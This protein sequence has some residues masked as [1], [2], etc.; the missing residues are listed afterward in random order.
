MNRLFMII[1]VVILVLALVLML[2][3]VLVLILALVLVFVFVLAL[4]LVFV[5]VLAFVLVFVFISVLG[6]GSRLYLVMIADLRV[7][8][9]SVVLASKV[10]WA[11]IEIEI[12]ITRVRGNQFYIF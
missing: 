10:G 7:A 12:V 2:A 5:F 6:F 9:K 8:R 3:L 11:D 4:V 1:C